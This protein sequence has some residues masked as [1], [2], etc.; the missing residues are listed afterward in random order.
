M[1]RKSLERDYEVTPKALFHVMFG[2]KSGVFQVLYAQR[3]SQRMCNSSFLFFLKAVRLTCGGSNPSRPVERARER[4]GQA[5]VRLSSRLD[6][7]VR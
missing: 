4:K 5:T 2:E 6:R 1:I 3:R 7:H